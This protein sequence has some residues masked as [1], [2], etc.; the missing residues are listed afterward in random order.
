MVALNLRHMWSTPNL[1]EVHSGPLRVIDASGS[2]SFPKSEFGLTRRVSSLDCRITTRTDGSCAYI[3][4]RSSQFLRFVTPGL[5]N[6][7]LGRQ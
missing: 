2:V 6:P 5:D 4:D 3:A 7:I 1:G